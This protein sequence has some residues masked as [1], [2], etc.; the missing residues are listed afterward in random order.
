MGDGG[1]SV[2]RGKIALGCMVA[3]LAVIAAVVILGGVLLSGLS[4]KGDGGETKAE[5]EEHAARE[6]PGVD[7]EVRE[8][9]DKS[10]DLWVTVGGEVASIPEVMDV[11][12]V[13]GEMAAMAEDAN[14][15]FDGSAAVELDDAPVPVDVAFDHGTDGAELRGVLEDPAARTFRALTVPAPTE[16]IALGGASCDLSDPQCF[17]DRASAA[18]TVEA[19]PYRARP[20]DS[21][22]FIGHVALEIPVSDAAMSEEEEE[23]LERGQTQEGEEIRRSTRV[24]IEVDGPA[25]RAA[26]A[27]MVRWAGDAAGRMAVV[28]LAGDGRVPPLRIAP[29]MSIGHLGVPRVTVDAYNVGDGPGEVRAAVERVA[30]VLAELEQASGGVPGADEGI[31]VTVDGLPE[32]GK[33]EVVVGGCS[34]EPAVEDAEK[35]LRARFETCR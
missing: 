5:L 11:H 23:R 14:W 28:G 7:V 29:S 22:R 20:S 8:T 13:L 31:H 1:G 16:P 34:A 32:Y 30:S 26:A 19:A 35:T 10:R 27:D 25:D 3:V 33:V 17:G 18:A 2:D 6:L 24:R 12:R 9:V 4:A 21:G 15:G